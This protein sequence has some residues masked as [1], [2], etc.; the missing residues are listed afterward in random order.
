MELRR[1]MRAT[2]RKVQKVPEMM[3]QY[4]TNDEK[5]DEE[6]QTFGVG[7]R[8]YELFQEVK[9]LT[10]EQ[11]DCTKKKERPGPGTHCSYTSEVQSDGEICNITL[12]RAIRP[13][14]L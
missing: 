1:A 8:Q 14:R 10:T 6:A 7:T 11:D 3:R 2:R 13:S 9:R 4:R 12:P 5:I